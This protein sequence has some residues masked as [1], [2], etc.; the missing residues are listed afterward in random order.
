LIGKNDEILT[1]NG[2]KN[3]IKLSE[4]VGFALPFG[5]AQRAVKRLS[6]L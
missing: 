6:L 1:L 2:Q 3:V 5:L 4:E